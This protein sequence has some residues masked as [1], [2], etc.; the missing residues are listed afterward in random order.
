MEARVHEAPEQVDPYELMEPSEILTKH[1]KNFNERLKE[2]NW[3][4]RKV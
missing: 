3:Q 2:K 1:P 4:E